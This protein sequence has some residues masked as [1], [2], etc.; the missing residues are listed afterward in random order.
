MSFPRPSVALCVAQAIA[1]R[2]AINAAAQKK[3]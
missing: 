1:L 2:D 3:A